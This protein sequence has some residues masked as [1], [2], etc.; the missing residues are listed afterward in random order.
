MRI[1]GIVAALIFV[2]LGGYGMQDCAAHEVLTCDRS[3]GSP[4]CTLVD[5]AFTSETRVFAD[6]SLAALRAVRHAAKGRPTYGVAVVNRAGDAHEVVH[7]LEELDAKRAEG[8]FASSEPRLELIHPR[9]PFGMVLA[10]LLIAIGLAIAAATAL[11]S[12]SRA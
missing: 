12:R 2:V 6:E 4:R 11:R 3:M 7:L 9:Y 8:W 5:G 1:F 10:G